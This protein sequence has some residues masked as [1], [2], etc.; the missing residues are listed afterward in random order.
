[1]TVA[2]LNLLS[3]ILILP[4]HSVFSGGLDGT[5]GEYPPS[6]CLQMS[7]ICENTIH[8]RRLGLARESA[9]RVFVEVERRF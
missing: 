9:T 5:A 2:I 3:T 1:L 4:K 6:F 8:I 7:S